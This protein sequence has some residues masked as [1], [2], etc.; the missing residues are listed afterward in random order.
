MTTPVNIPLSTEELKT[1]G[2]YNAECARGIAHREEWIRYMVSLQR[3]FAVSQCMS[4][5]AEC[6]KNNPAGRCGCH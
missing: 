6:M 2:T 5:S 1:L 4:T 3:R